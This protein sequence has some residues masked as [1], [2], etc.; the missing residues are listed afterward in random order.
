MR[1][2][3]PR[4]AICGATAS[5]TAGVATG[6]GPDG[7]LFP[8]ARRGPARRPTSSTTARAAPSPSPAPDD[9]RLGRAA[10]RGR[11]APSVRHHAGARRRSRAD[12][13]IA[14]ADGGARARASRISFDGN[15]RAQLWQRRGQR[16]ARDPDAAG[17][18]GRHPVRQSSRHLAAARPRFRRRRRGPAARGR[19]GRLRGLPKARADRLDRAPRRGCRHATASPPGSTAATAPPRP[20]RSSSPGSSTGSAPATPSPPACCTACAS[21]RDLDWTV[22]CRP[23]ARLPQAQPARRREPVRAARHRRVPR[24]RAATSGADMLEPARLPRRGGRRG[25]G[26]RCSCHR[27]AKSSATRRGPAGTV[28][29]QRWKRASLSFAVSATARAARFLAPIAVAGL[30]RATSRRVDFGPSSPQRGSA[31]P[32]DERGLPV[33]QRLDARR[34]AAARSGRSWSISTAALIRAGARPIPLLDGRRLAAR[35]DVVV[36]TVN[37]RLNAFGYLYL[38][39]LDPRFP[40]S[41][42]AGQLDLI[43]ALRMGARQYRG[44][45]RRS[46]ARSWCSASR[47]AAPRSRR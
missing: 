45:R 44:V 36:V 43:L 35:G 41:G 33:P 28:P 37:H 24:R 13:P 47:A 18:R 16:S 25:R 7:P 14:A 40:D 42:N 27:R 10:R 6:A 39:R 26:R 4:P 19:R 11:P 23:R 8:V 5:T 32:A 46:R 38:A 20:R 3:M 30:V 15:Y 31:V 1:S 9:Y 21:G 29:R 17:R 34:R 12:A 22:A 2:A